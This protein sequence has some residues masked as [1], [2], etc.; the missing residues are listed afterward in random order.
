MTPL[1]PLGIIDQG[2]YLIIIFIIGLF[3][4]L[5][6]E[7]SGFSSS[8]KLAGVFYGYD[9]VV[10]KVFFTAGITAM[11]GLV[12]M[13]YFGL[14]DLSVIF[15]NSNFLLSALV[16]GA[17]MGFGFILGGFCPGTSVTGAVIG[18]IDAMVFIAGI[19]LGIFVF[20]AFDTTFNKLFTGY[21]FDHE[22]ISETLGFSKHFMVF[23]WILMALAAFGVAGYFEKRSTVGL[24]PTNVRYP[25]LGIEVFLA[26]VI[27]VVILFLPEQKAKGLFQV[28]EKKVL[29]MINDP[30]SMMDA[31]E[32]AY[33][34]INNPKKLNII[35]VRDEASYASFHIPGSARVPL[36][37]IT[38]KG[39][40]DM[41]NNPLKKTVLVSEGGVDAGKA[42][43]LLAR[44]GH[45]NIAVLNGGLNAFTRTIFLENTPP[46]G[47]TAFD[48]ISKYRFRQRA[49]SYF[50][51]EGA[52]PSRGAQ[53]KKRNIP[54]AASMPSTG[55][56]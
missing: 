4:G 6:L 13:G 53:G 37:R 22:L 7:Q 21:Y 32:L 46:E 54:T 3:F 25:R 45:K 10:L 48:D 2:W 15:V 40:L 38:S 20:G 30:Q 12:I 5:V 14:I 44:K 18:K 52:S 24:R 41:F 43:V 49:A 9:F 42:L 33:L 1:F 19:F 55:G 34:I 39:Y 27:A 17:I 23:V 28:N 31:D 35:D 50:R 11:S 47:L 36:D 26:I 29:S 56:C 51:S 8:R 16:G